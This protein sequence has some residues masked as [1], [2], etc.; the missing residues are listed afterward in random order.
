MF[1][2]CH[3]RFIN[4]TNSHPERI[5]NQDTKIVDTLDYRSITFSMKARD[6]EL[7]EERFN[8]N[9]NVFDMRIEFFHYMYQ[10]N[11]MNKH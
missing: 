8:I 7:A 2:R 4:P 6:Y 10:K 9:V 5:N 3:I 1:K 11:Q